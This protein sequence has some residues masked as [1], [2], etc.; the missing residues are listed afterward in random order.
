M[1][2]IV[3]DPEFHAAIP[4]LSSEELLQ[5]EENIRRDGCLDALV[6]WPVH[7][8]DILLDG[9][10]RYEICT[11]LHLPFRTTRIAMA[12]RDDALIWILQQ[13][14]GRRN[15]SNLAR[16]ALALQLKPMLGAQAKR[17]MS[18]GGK[19]HGNVHRSQPLANVPNL[20]AHDTR[21][22]L[23]LLA[24]VSGKTFASGEQVL[25]HG[26]PEVIQA[27]R[28]HTLSISAAVPLTVLPKAD[29]PAALDAATQLAHG[30]KISM[31]IA[32]AVV[33]QMQPLSPSLTPAS[34]SP[35]S[36]SLAPMPLPTS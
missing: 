15:L 11:R 24:G 36:L 4:P 25:A 5:L 3:I 31:T 16:I 21:A 20:P 23:A 34:P 28:A 33:H 7:G 18:E 10:N 6:V 30:K 12:T 8:Q 1:T 29:Q 27:V 9:H 22:S 32:N 14:L 26:A 17:R 2:V 35:H 19:K 13:Q